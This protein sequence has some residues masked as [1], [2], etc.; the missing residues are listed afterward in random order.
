MR[1]DKDFMVHI[2]SHN[3]LTAKYLINVSR[4]SIEQK[5]F[6]FLNQSIDFLLSQG[7]DAFASTIVM[8]DGYND[9]SE[10]I[11]EIPE[12]RNWVNDLL[13]AHP[14]FIY[15][16][17]RA[18]DTHLDLLSCVGDIAIRYS[19]EKTLSPNEY[20]RLGIDPLTEVERKQWTISINEILYKRMELAL[21]LLGTRIDDPQGTNETITMLAYFKDK[22]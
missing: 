1:T 17:S 18:T 2:D 3:S 8:F 12:V 15:F 11:Y 9:T 10:E 22:H 16:A 5:S 21:R 7:S 6:E 14:Y 4:N 19:G 13:L 20:A